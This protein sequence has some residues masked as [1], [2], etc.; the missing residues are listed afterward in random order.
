MGVDAASAHDFPHFSE[1]PEA[2]LQQVLHQQQ[3]KFRSDLDFQVRTNNA[4]RTMARSKEQE[5]ENSQMD[6]NREEMR[7]I[8]LAEK[9]RRD[10]D[11]HAL[12]ESW[13]QD[14]RMKGI[15]R[16]IENHCNAAGH[17]D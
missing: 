6:A 10:A 3:T 11:K 1:P 7:Q 17:A 9:A 13:N 5:L 16:A 15:W 14:M 4:L 12:T 8:R 2:E